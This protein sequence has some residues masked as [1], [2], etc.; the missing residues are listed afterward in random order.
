MIIGITGGSG[1][2]KTT[3]LECIRQMG[4]LVLDCDAVYHRLLREDKALL[5]AIEKRFPGSVEQGQLQRK[6][7]GSQVFSDPEALGDLNRITHGAVYREVE[8]Q[9]KSE[10]RLAAIDA[11]ALFESGLAELCDVTVAVVAPWESR[12]RRLMAREGI[13]REYAENRLRAQKSDAWYAQKCQY[14]LENGGG[15]VC[16]RQKCL[17]FFAGVV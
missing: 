9:R 2:G 15:M 3:A 11:I 6:K 1:C 4:G 14:T 13:S 10:P 5:E 17:Q 8:R 7:L 12:V 16:F